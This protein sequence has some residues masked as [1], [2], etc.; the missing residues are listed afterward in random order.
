VI[1]QYKL[2]S[3]ASVD[4]AI[5]RSL[6]VSTV[7]NKSRLML[8]PAHMAAHYIWKTAVLTIETHFNN[9][10]PCGRAARASV[11]RRPTKID[12]I[13]SSLISGSDSVSD[14]T[15]TVRNLAPYGLP[16]VPYDRVQEPNVDPIGRA[17]LRSRP[18]RV[19]FVPK[20]RD[21]G[22]SGHENSQKNPPT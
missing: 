10:P 22:R 9:P 5:R 6:S 14:D 3:I 16:N 4:A 21:R 1:K 7:E 11:S 13:E 19:G 20:R 17:R 2:P 8:Q 18:K 12:Q 15:K